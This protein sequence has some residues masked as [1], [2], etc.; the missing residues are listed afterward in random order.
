MTVKIYFRM[1]LT[2]TLFLLAATSIAQAQY[3]GGSGTADDPYQIATAADLIALGETP[4]DYDK[5]F[6]LTADIDLDPNLPGRKVFDRA[7]I[8]PDVND[9]PNQWGRNP[10]DGQP[11][12]GELDGDCHTISNLTIKGGNWLGLFGQLERP[13]TISNLSLEAVDVNGTAY[14]GGLVGGNTGTI[15]RSHSTG[16]VSGNRSI[17]GLV[18]NHFAGS[19]A[20][21]WS[22]ATIRGN[23]DAIGGLAGDN[24]GTIT[25]SYSTGDVTGDNVVGGLVGSNMRTIT[26]SYSTGDVT[27]NSQVGGLAGE[28]IALYDMME[29]VIGVITACYSTGVVNGNQDVGGLVGMLEQYNNIFGLGVLIRAVTTD[30][31][32]SDCYD[33]RAVTGNE[34]VWGLIGYSDEGK[35]TRSHSTG[36]VAGNVSVGGLLDELG[37][38]ISMCYS[39]R[40]VNGDTRVGGL[41]GNDDGGNVTSSYWDIETSSL[42]NM[43]GSQSD[44]GTDCDDAFGL[45]TAEMQTASTFEQVGWGCSPVW[46]IDEGN[47][48]PRLSWENRPG[49][50][51]GIWP[52]LGPSRGD[53]T[54][55]N[56][57]QI[58]TLEDAAI[59]AGSPCEGDIHFQLM[60]LEGDGSPEN[61]YLVCDVNDIEILHGFPL[62]LDKHFKLLADIDLSGIVWS[63]AVFPSFSGT[64]DGSGCEISNLTIIG[65]NDFLGLFGRLEVGSAVRNLGIVD[66]NISGVGDQVGGLAGS[67]RGTISASYCTGIVTGSELVGG[68]TGYNYGSIESCCTT[69]VTTGDSGVGGITGINGGDMTMSYSTGTVSGS[70]W[71]GGL[72]G[73][74]GGIITYC[75]SIASI[76]GH[77]HIAGGLTGRNVGALTDCYARSEVI[78]GERVGGLVGTNEN[79][80]TRCHY[81]GSV[82]GDRFVGGC[83]GSNVINGTSEIVS[84]FWDSEGSGLPNM[85]GLGNCDDAGG[86]TT[87]EMQTATTFLEAGWDFIDETENGTDDIWWILEGQ[88]YPRLWWELLEEEAEEQTNNPGSLIS[89]W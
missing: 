17:G 23:R 35:I 2:L 20:Q 47:D 24:V 57:Y 39:S 77:A 42:L 62:Q 68:L 84:C 51:I 16:V 32:V 28:H 36:E 26:M 14:V 18:G 83:V 49:E 82:T 55:G 50:P 74:S 64:F 89:A 52:L 63:E 10:C 27:G 87:A 58:H 22:S 3:S 71:V 80:I 34:N 29:D 11:F 73:T 48:Y 15:T 70:G 37:P 31:T 67:N 7:V 30:A 54:P 85:C 66:V 86:R 69:G 65:D 46:T 59:V 9:T 12:K 6:I 19:I 61:P 8:A 5:H 25:M 4:D 21:C 76:V 40:R 72:A 1:S 53:G 13:S 78:G 45:T 38:Y 60:F 81:A 41:V 44:E 43:C 79:L 88:D 56:P 75:Y 33:S